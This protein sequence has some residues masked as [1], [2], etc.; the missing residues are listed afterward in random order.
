[1]GNP[2]KRYAEVWAQPNPD[3]TR[4]LALF[5]DGCIAVYGY[6][7]IRGDDDKELERAAKQFARRNGCELTR[8]KAKRTRS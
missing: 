8:L 1:M 4:Q 7:D 2:I 5:E 3:G 6:Y